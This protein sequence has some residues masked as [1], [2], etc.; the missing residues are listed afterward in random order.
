MRDIVI[1]RDKQHPLLL[2]LRLQVCVCVFVIRKMA[3]IQNNAAMIRCSKLL[4]V[5]PWG[6]FY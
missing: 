4:S 5:Y 3:W 2:F 6:P 1:D